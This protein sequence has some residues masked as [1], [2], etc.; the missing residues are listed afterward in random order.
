MQLELGAH[1]DHGAAGVVDALAE[2]VLAEAPLLALQH[3]GERLE[4][5]LVGPGDGLAAPA[6]VEERVDRLLQ[7]PL[8]VADDDV[9]GVQLHEPLQPV[10]AVDDAAVEVVQVGG[11]EAAA[12]ERHQRAQVGRDDRDDLEHH[13]VGLVARLAEGVDHLEPLGDL[14]ALGVGGGLL[15]LGAQL[16]GEP[17][18]LDVAEQRQDRLAAHAGVEGL[19]AHLLAQLLVAVLGEE[20]AAQQ[21]GLLGVGDDVRLTVKDLLEVLQGDVEQ[22]ADAAGERLEEPDVGHR[23]GQRDVAETLAPHLALD[24]LDAALLAHHPAVLHALV[25]AAVALVVLHGAED[26][27]AEEAVPLRLEGAVV[28]GLRL[29]HLAVRPLPDLVR[30]GQRDADGGER[31]RVLGLLEEIEDVLHVSSLDA[32]FGFRVIR[33]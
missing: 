8:L 13:P 29:L 15:H 22:V 9:G 33:A 18:H 32:A 4:R 20:L 5:A 10:V 30:A 17:V 2:Q 7:H 24:D 12:V 1:H 3:V 11:G 31:R 21:R 23:G 27:G 25:L 19:L 26:L 6:V 28:D 14:L 16:L